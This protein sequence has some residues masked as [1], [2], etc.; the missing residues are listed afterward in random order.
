MGTGST[1]P[2]K[3]REEKREV[4]KLVVVGGGPSGKTS[5]IKRYCYD[6]FSANNRVCTVS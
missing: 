2:E 5:L 4:V 6:T 1:I 3:K